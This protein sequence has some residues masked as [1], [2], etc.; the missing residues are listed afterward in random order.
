MLA[1]R[2]LQ[3]EAT[4]PMESHGNTPSR[5]FDPLQ[6]FQTMLTQLLFLLSMGLFFKG[7]LAP[8]LI[9]LAVYAVTLVVNKSD[10]HGF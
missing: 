10:D 1:L 6:L 5:A 9:V 7:K 3:Q 4:P 2:L 8:A